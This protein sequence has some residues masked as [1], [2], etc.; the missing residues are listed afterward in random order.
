MKLIFNVDPQT[1]KE[2]INEDRIQPT[3]FDIPI[4]EQYKLMFEITEYE[5]ENIQ[6][7]R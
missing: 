7:W 6:R 4:E 3:N 5:A 2:L 1:L